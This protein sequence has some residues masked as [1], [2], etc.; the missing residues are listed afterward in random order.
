MS[1]DS[2]EPTLVLLPGLHGTHHLFQPLL[3]V[4]P[5][6]VPTRVISHPAHESCGY[7]ELLRR[8]E[9]QLEDE[10]QVILFAESFSGPIGLH[11]A[12]RHPQKVRALVLCASF[13]AP[14]VPAVL[15]YLA[16][17]LIWLRFPIPGLAIRTFLS[18]FRAPRELVRETR[19]VI[20]LLNPR[21][22][23]HRVR[24]TTRAQAKKELAH[25]KVPIL[26][27]A[28]TRDRLIGARSLRR[29][30]RIRPDMEVVTFDTSHLL[31][32]MKP[33]EVWEAMLRFPAVGNWYNAAASKL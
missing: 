3:D 15:C 14:P 12:I 1:A 25:C 21:V 20:R 16:T 17:P 13:A 23:A 22:L 31:L 18:G 7:P 24:E 10:S 11:F 5:P 2:S 19:N 28:A 6:S 4:I 29:M 26:C 27:L 30:R 32:Q 9:Q 8:V 33:G